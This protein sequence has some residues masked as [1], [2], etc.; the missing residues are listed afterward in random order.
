MISLMSSDDHQPKRPS[1][2]QRARA[3]AHVRAPLLIDPLRSFLL[4]PEAEAEVSAFSC[5]LRLRFS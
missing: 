4:P 2:S 3:C 1:S 5:C